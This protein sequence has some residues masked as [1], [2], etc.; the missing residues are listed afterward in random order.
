MTENQLVV[1]KKIRDL[2]LPKASI[3]GAIQRKNEDGEEIRTA[4]GD[5]EI[6]AGDHVIIFALPEA[7]EAIEKLFTRRR[8]F[9]R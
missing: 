8:G 6:L 9:L 2:K 7:V 5:T 4:G 3:I 1:G